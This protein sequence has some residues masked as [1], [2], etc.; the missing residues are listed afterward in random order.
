MIVK[1]ETHEA[2]QIAGKIPAAR[3]GSG[4]ATMG[5]AA[6]NAGTCGG[7]E[8]TFATLAGSD[9]LVVFGSND[10]AYT[11]S[12]HGVAGLTKAAAIDYGARGIRVNAV[13]PGPVWTPLQVSGGQTQENLKKFGG[14]TPMKR[15]G[16]PAERVQDVRN[17]A[18]LGVY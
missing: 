2:I 14:D 9:A 17:A 18:G 3:V 11:A 4:R 15:P 10:A 5:A 12:K 13:A 8:T 6:G 16:Q 1:A 7:A